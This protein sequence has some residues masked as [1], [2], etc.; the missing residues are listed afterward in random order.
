ML[1]YEEKN[2]SVVE[3]GTFCGHNTVLRM[4]PPT[5]WTEYKENKRGKSSEYDEEQRII[6][7]EINAPQI[8]T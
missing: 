5:M 4:R 6:S 3:L 2:W 1:G 8:Y 7:H